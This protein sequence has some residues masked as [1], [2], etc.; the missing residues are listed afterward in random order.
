MADRADGESGR[1]TPSYQKADRRG[2]GQASVEQKKSP[3]F[4]GLKSNSF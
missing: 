2:A 1:F 4:G 3:L